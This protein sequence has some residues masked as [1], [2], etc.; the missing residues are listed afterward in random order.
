[1]NKSCDKVDGIRYDRYLFKGRDWLEYALQMAMKGFLICYLFY[2]SFKVWFLLIPF[3]VMDYRGMKKK[4]LRGQKRTLMVQFRSFIEAIANGLSAGYSLERGV[5]EARRDLELLYPVD[6]LIFQE[7]DVILAGLHMNVPV[8]Q[9]FQEFGN[10]T[11]V[12]DIKNFAN[13]VTVAKRSGGNM[14]HIIQKTVNCMGDKL[15]VEE[16]I[17]TMIAAKKYE[18]RIMML[19][20][21]GII[22]YLRISN[23]SFFDVLYHNMVG[24]IIMTVFL[25]AVYLADL[26]AQRIMEIEV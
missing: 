25:L 17:E 8:E 11:E 13:V 23:G 21:Y 6:S 20:P 26:W 14:V 2:D 12:D 1:M 9:L 15:A 10:R 18:E 16:E 19:M 24:V 7:M 3:G 4:K 5:K 22:G